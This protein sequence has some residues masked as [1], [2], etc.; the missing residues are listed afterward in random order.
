VALDIEADL[1]PTVATGMPEGTVEHRRVSF[2]VRPVAKWLQRRA[3]R[4][5]L[6]TA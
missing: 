3:Q 4:C 6:Y 1:W 2:D 5:A